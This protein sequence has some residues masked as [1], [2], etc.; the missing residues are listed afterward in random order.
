MLLF[1]EDRY[2]QENENIAPDN[3]IPISDILELKRKINLPKGQEKVDQVVKKTNVVNVFSG[4]IHETDVAIAYGIFVGLVDGYK[5]K[6]FYSAQGKFMCLGLID[7]HI[8]LESTFLSPIEFCNVVAIHGTSG[9]ICDPHEIA[10]VLGLRLIDYIL[11]TSHGLPVKIFL[12]MPSGVPASL[13]RAI[14]D[15]VHQ[16]VLLVW[17]K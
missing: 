4:D 12:M 13:D 7:G 10:N 3:L 5:A 6:H 9:V 1:S 16:T 17:Q 14:S 15:Y 8:H 11:Q 2:T